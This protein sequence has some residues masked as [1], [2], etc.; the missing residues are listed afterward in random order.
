MY[1]ILLI[2]GEPVDQRF[3]LPKNLEIEGYLQGAINEM[4]EPYEDI[5]DLSEKKPTFLLEES[6]SKKIARN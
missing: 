2:D 4:K 3:I 1:L 6:P 5:I